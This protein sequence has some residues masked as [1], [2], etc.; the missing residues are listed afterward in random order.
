MATNVIEAF[1]RMIGQIFGVDRIGEE[2]RQEFATQAYRVS[3]ERGL[4]AAWA[5]F[6]LGLPLF[7]LIDFATWKSGQW[8]VQPAHERIF[9]WRVA[10]TG[11]LVTLLV[12]GRLIPDERKC[13]R[14]FA[15]SSAIAF[16]LFGAWFAI[17][18]QTLITDASIYALFLIGTAV[19]FPLPLLRKLLIY[20]ATLLV[21]LAGLTWT[22]A[23]PVSM[24]HVTVNAT[25][26]GIGAIV[27]EAVAMR[28]YAADFAKSIEIELERR[29]ADTLLRNVLPATVAERLKRDPTTR[30]EHHPAVSVLF[31]DFVGFGK[32][33]QDLPP[34][35][36]I[37]LL[38]Q[39][40]HEFDE[41]ADRFGVEKIKTLGDSYMAACGVPAAQP[42]HALRTAQLAL[43]IQA[44]AGR[45]KSDRGLPVR[46]RV[47]LHTGP[48]IA[49]VIGRKKFCYDLWGDTI[50]F[51]A[52]LQASSAPD[53]IHVSEA[54]RSALGDEFRFAAREPIALKGRAQV[55]TYDLIG[56]TIEGEPFN[57]R[58]ARMETPA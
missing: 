15:W 55:S 50:N 49:G 36:M 28:T 17:V 58:L 6:V 33:T 26:V 10:L 38:D 24:Y 7:L 4:R 43:R 30:V 14:V 44:I 11:L 29:R 42:D 54:M 48:A 9:W 25:C 47:G 21:L 22:S 31:A 53:R 23:D 41:A 56:R 12:L 39:L 46:V 19:L 40:F 52:Q 3:A 34:E 37:A 2:S 1:V 20:P 5:V 27:V 57:D 32:L 18:C 8:D 45:F 13:D 51:A 35:Q 16:P